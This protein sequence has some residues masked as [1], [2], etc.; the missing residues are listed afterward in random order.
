MA[1]LHLEKYYFDII[2]SH[3]QVWIGY[4]ARIKLFGISIYYSQSLLKQHG[5][6]KVK[7]SFK[8]H[9]LPSIESSISST[10]SLFSLKSLG[11]FKSIPVQR[12]YENDGGF[13]D[14]QVIAPSST[15]QV[16][17]PQGLLDGKGYLEKLTLTISPWRLP[18]NTLY[19]GR[20]IGSTHHAV[21][22]RWHHSNEKMWLFID[23][24]ETE[25]HSISEHEISFQ[26][27]RI[28]ITNQSTL[29]ECQPFRQHL[30]AL[31]LLM[32]KKFTSLREQKWHAQGEL[33]I[34][35]ERDKG[36]IIHE[37]VSFT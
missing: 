23:G 14:W 33:M 15:F 36:T 3:N 20:F 37:R 30:Y 35:D 19:W 22:I 29:L 17:L 16:Q 9:E 7:S 4:S 32:P 31:K 5:I 18:I 27:G 6:T 34:G 2:S 8:Y 21:W 24:K 11:D 28:A 25:A 12:L 13:A 26:Q 1:F 10:T